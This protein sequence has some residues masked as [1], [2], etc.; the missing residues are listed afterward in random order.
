MLVIVVHHI[1]ADGFSLTPLARDVMT[2]YAARIAGSAPQWNPLSVQYADYTLWQLQL[3]GDE[4]DAESLISQQLRY[5]TDQLADLPELLQLPTDRARPVQQSFRGAQVDFT[6]P[7]DV[8]RA[9]AALARKHNSTMFMA[10]HAA[11]SVL[12]SA[13]SSTEDIAVGTPHRGPW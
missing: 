3:L 12:L 8:H 1:C 2:A 5:W 4:S 7:A 6:I 10:V 9:L 13:L 11:L